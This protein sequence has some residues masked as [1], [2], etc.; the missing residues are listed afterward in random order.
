M[1]DGGILVNKDFMYALVSYF[2][3]HRIYTEGKYTVLLDRP[4]W[5]EH[6]VSSAAGK[7]LAALLADNSYRIFDCLEQLY[8]SD[9]E[10]DYVIEVGPNII[11]IEVKSGAEGRLRSLKQFMEEKK[12]ILGLRISQAPLAFEGNILSVPFYM[13]R[14]IPRLVLDTIYDLN[15]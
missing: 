12:S 11:P 10:V 13:I 2:T 7:S 15:Q 5:A 9:A 8:G 4:D 1:V 3:Y 14:E 6:Y